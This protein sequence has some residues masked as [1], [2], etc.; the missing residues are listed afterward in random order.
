[1]KDAMQYSFPIRKSASTT[2]S[3]PHCGQPLTAE[4]SCREAHMHCTACGHYFPMEKFIQIADA[5]LENFLDGLYID[6][7]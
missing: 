2:L 7:I 4:R 6:R 5:A 3:C 1:M